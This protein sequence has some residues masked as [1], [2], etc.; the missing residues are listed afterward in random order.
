[1]HATMRSTTLITPH[2]LQEVDTQLTTPITADE[3]PV[4]NY[5]KCNLTIFNAQVANGGWVPRDPGAVT[6][7]TPQGGRAP[8][9]QYHLQPSHEPPAPSR[10]GLRGV[11]Q[12]GAIRGLRAPS[13]SPQGPNPEAPNTKNKQE[14][15]AKTPTD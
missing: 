4:V 3:L 14:I 7:I 13:H 1:M 2:T 6:A 9:D 8:S 12:P 5:V 11:E 15:P 10:R